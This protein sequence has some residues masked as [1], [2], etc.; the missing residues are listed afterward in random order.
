MTRVVMLILNNSVFAL[1]VIRFNTIFC[2]ASVVL[3][4]L[5]YHIINTKIALV[6][7]L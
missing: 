3:G 4:R 6:S 2:V 5:Y 1:E 7:F